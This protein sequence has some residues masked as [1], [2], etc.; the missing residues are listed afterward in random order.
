M[1]ISTDPAASGTDAGRVRHRRR[2]DGR[3]A[4]F[5]DWPGWLPAE[6]VESLRAT[7]LERPWTHQVTAAEAAYSGSH[8]ALTTGTASGKTLG[9]LMPVLAA[10]YGGVAATSRAPV[11][12]RAELRELIVKPKRPHTALYLAPTK[13]LAHDQ[14]RVTD[15]VGLPD[16]RVAAVDGDSER[17]ERDWAREH[18]SYVLTNPDFVHYSM[19]PRHGRWASFLSALRYVV[20]DEAHRYRGVFGSHVAQVIRRL[21]RLCA[22]HGSHPTFILASATVTAAEEMVSE[23]IGCSTDEVTVVDRDA[24]PHGPVEMIMWDPEAY[25]TD[26]AAVLLA[27]LVTAGKQTVAFIPSRRMA[28]LTAVRAQERASRLT[29]ASEGLTV[30]PPKEDPRIDSYRS[31]YL[32]ADRR[33]LERALQDG[34]LHGLAATNAL[35]LGVDV[36]GL[37][38]VIICGFPGTRSALWQQAGRAGRSGREAEVILIAAKNPLDAY[39]FDHPGLLFDEPVEKTVLHADNPYVLGPHL[40]AAAQELPLTDTDKVWFG[41]SMINTLRRLEAQGVLRKRPAGWFWSRPDRAVDSVDLRGSGGPTV[42]IIEDESGRV[43]GTVDQAAADGT[44]HEGAVYLHQGETYLVDELDL[45]ESEALVHAARLGYYT[46]PRGSNEVEVVAEQFT[47]PFGRGILHY[48]DVDVFSQVIGYLRR[49]EVTSDVWDETPLDMP[50][51]RLRTKAVWWT[52]DAAALDLSAVQLGSAAHAAEHTAIGLLP[53]FAPCDRWDIG[54]LSTVLHP[55]TGTLTVFVHDGQ[56]GGA[57]FAER[58]YRVADDWWQ[59]TLERLRSCECS[60]GCPSCVVSPKCGNANQMLDKQAAIWL[61]EAL[62]V[63]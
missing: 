23:L 43:L 21:R 50:E 49:D 28:E 40:A 7:G 1:T 4:E 34:S 62:L 27:D 52:F 16:W 18:A 29:G 26:E 14:L 31:G 6:I 35:E 59:A 48:G 2:L 53:M 45:E 9:Y 25:P 39:Y 56:A 3:T 32:A 17:Q 51:R 46:E 36:A 57:G 8:V 33:A 58:G 55:D 41:D 22:A 37:D 44:V 10:T 11:G 30:N 38:A 47:R 24:S 19:L 54:G 20:I 42:D 12:G 63:D 60:A 13:A 61:L 15:Q 5:G